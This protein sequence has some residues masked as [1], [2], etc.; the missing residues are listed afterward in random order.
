M[1]RTNSK[2]ILLQ[3]HPLM[4][5]L[6]I[7]LFLILT[8][9]IMML[10]TGTAS[11][12]MAKGVSDVS[13][14]VSDNVRPLPRL[15]AIIAYVLGAAFA[16]HGLLKLRDWTNDSQRNSLKP[17]LFRFVIAALLV[18]LPYS[19]VIINN[20]LFGQGEGGV[21]VSIPAPKLNAFTK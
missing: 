20:S 19:F 13:R 4:T 6:W 16:A 2:A 3:R 7:G 17:A 11:A 12:Q 8:V 18:W 15:V 9:M 1:R 14:N 21:Q 10:V 5:G